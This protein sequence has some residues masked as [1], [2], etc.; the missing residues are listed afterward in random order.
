MG[1]Q[2][3]ADQAFGRIRSIRYLCKLIMPF[4]GKIEEV[5]WEYCKNPSEFNSIFDEKHWIV[6]ILVNERVCKMN[7]VKE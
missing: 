2:L 6:K 5:N 4:S 7:C 1:E 3:D